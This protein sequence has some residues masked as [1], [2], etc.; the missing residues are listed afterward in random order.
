MRQQVTSI[1]WCMSPHFQQLRFRSF[2]LPKLWAQQ[3]SLSFNWL[4]PMKCVGS[5]KI[6]LI[7]IEKLEH[8][9]VLCFATYLKFKNDDD[10]SLNIILIYVH[11]LLFPIRL[12]NL[13]NK[14]TF[15]K[16]SYPFHCLFQV[17]IKMPKSKL[18]SLIW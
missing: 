10:F 13:K 9:S 16:I 15:S 12:N 7:T 1:C 2:R 6:Y 5:W 4:L 14:S 18:P 11:I 3:P 17:M 8:C